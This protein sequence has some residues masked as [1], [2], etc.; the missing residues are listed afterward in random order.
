MSPIPLH[1]KTETTTNVNNNKGQTHLKINR[2]SHSIKKPSSSSSSSPSNKQQRQPVIIYTHSPRIIHTNPRD[3]MQLVQK[4]TGLSRSKEQQELQPK[5]EPEEAASVPLAEEVE[6]PM[7]VAVCKDENEASSVIM[8]KS[9]C[10]SSSSSSRR[11]V[12]GPPPPLM[13]PPMIPYVNRLPVFGPSSAEFL[14]CSN[15][16]LFSY[17]DPLFF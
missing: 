17:A 15:K 8:E 1:P 14:M 3:F 2:D 5:P 4:L 9:N 13:E 12:A 11:L 6:Y 7:K 16:A 10:I